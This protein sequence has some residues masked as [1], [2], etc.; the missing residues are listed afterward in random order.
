M[1][2]P[3]ITL[4]LLTNIGIKSEQLSLF[5]SLYGANGTLDLSRS[6]IEKTY[7]LFN[8]GLI[9][10]KLLNAHDLQDFFNICHPSLDA[11]DK[12][13]QKSIHYVEIGTYCG[14]LMAEM[15]EKHPKVY[16]CF[17]SRAAKTFSM[18]YSQKMAK[19]A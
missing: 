1:N 5:V 14:A 13:A 2:Y 18:L 19:V 4:S 17:V 10:E 3:S 6:A 16:E 7:H 11:F 8:W 12:I 15:K 9:A